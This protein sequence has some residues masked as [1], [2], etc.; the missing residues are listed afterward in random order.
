M[1]KRRSAPSRNRTRC[2]KKTRCVLVVDDEAIVRDLTQ[3]MCEMAFGTRV[4][5]ASTNKQALRAAKRRRFD[6]VITDYI[7]SGGNGLDFLREFKRRHP[8]TP[9]VM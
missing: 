1:K 8:R 4:V 9:V 7:R 5:Q 6:L 2:P 3:L